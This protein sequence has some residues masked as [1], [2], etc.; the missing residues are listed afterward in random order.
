MPGVG[1]NQET[2]IHRTDEPEFQADTHSP[3]RVH[4]Q[5]KQHIRLSEDNTFLYLKT[6]QMLPTKAHTGKIKIQPKIVH[7][8]E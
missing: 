4:N 5:P 6:T 3:V 8:G 1:Q 2:Q 7:I